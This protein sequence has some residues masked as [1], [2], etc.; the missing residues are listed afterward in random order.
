MIQKRIKNIILNVY[1][2]LYA[3][4]GEDFDKILEKDRE[5]WF[6]NYYVSEEDLELVLKKNLRY[7]REYVRESSYFKYY[8]GWAKVH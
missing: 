6:L 2:D 3:L 5:F 8:R 1:K 4:C 7:Q